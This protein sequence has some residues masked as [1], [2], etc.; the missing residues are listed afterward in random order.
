MKAFSVGLLSGLLFLTSCTKPTPSQR[1]AQIPEPSVPVV[2]AAL[3]PTKPKAESIP[4]HS[5]RARTI[6]RRG[7]KLTLVSF[8]RRNYRLVVADQSSGPGSRYDNAKDAGDGHLAS[9]NGGFFTPAGGPLGLVVTDGNHR[10][11]VNRASFLGTG[12]FLGP[13]AKLLSRTDYLAT[14]PSHQEV[15]QSGPRLVWSGE[16]PTGLSNK[17]E[18]PR[19][20]LLWD[21]KEHFALGYANSASLKGLSSLLQSQPISGFK[22]A[23]ALNL[24]GGRSCDFWVSSSVNGG[25][26][27]RSSFFKK[28]VRNYLVL[29]R[30]P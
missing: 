5:L 24:D 13:K 30:I 16:T 8:D 1:T 26:F 19:S 2:H 3:E 18:R 29:K 9:I 6:E 4:F 17:D 11:G 20:F 25:G 15:L 14:S 21:G 23:Y 12:F 7:I 28:D 10:G 22:I 27:T